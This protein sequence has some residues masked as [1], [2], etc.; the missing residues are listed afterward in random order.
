MK[1]AIQKK[2][3]SP[4]LSIFRYLMYVFLL[5]VSLLLI[6]FNKENTVGILLLSMIVFLISVSFFFIF[7][8]Q[9]I[10]PYKTLESR[11]M[12]L[13]A[14]SN[15]LLG[16]KVHLTTIIDGKLVKAAPAPT[17]K[18]FHFVWL[19]SSSIAVVKS[20]Q[21]NPR[22]LFTGFSCLNHGEEILACYSTKPQFITLGPHHLENPYQ[23]L[24]TWESQESYRARK[25]RAADTMAITMDGS[26]ICATIHVQFH[27]DLKRLQA[28]IDKVTSQRQRHQKDEK[29]FLHLRTQSDWHGLVSESVVAAWREL[30][31]QLTSEEVRFPKETRQSTQIF[32]GEHI[33]KVLT[34]SQFTS[35]PGAIQ[36]RQSNA[37][38]P[39]YIRLKEAGIWITDVSIIQ[40]RMPDVIEEQILINKD[41]QIQSSAILTRRKVLNKISTL[42]KDAT[43]LADIEFATS[44]ARF[45]NGSEFEGELSKSQKLASIIKGLMHLIRQSPPL[46]TGF[47]GRY[48]QLTNLQDQL[49]HASRDNHHG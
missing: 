11:W 10:F 25:E 8:T 21:T 26:E 24:Q 19:D 29:F 30:A 48:Q 46:A 3:K 36:D 41:L 12:G 17:K 2:L 39:L 20:G 49:I 33:K 7:F 42:Q 16:A 28:G 15:F 32:M 18:M 6:N 1:N 4:A 47:Q 44:L 22:I 9:I 27:I 35:S 38:N 23:T 5:L 45:L 43:I 37:F 40:I 31:R 14:F 13:V 34:R